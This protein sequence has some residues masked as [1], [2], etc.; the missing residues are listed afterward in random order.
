MPIICNKFLG[1]LGCSS[2]YQVTFTE[3]GLPESGLLCSL[4]IGCSVPQ[5]N[6]TLDGAAQ[7]S[8]GAAITT[9]Y[10]TQN[11]TYAYSITTPG[12]NNYTANPQS[13]SIEVHGS[14]VNVAV[15]FTKNNNT[16]NICY[17]PIN[18]TLGSEGPCIKVSV[19]QCIGTQPCPNDTAELYDALTLE[20]APAS[21]YYEV[22]DDTQLNE[23]VSDLSNYLS[24]K[25]ILTT[26]LTNTTG[27]LEVV[28]NNTP[29]SLKNALN[30][31]DLFICGSEVVL[32]GCREYKC[33]G[34][35]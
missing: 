25:G 24:Q 9:F 16:N 11:G 31:L 5:W 30:G 1:I 29:T 14:K 6:V 26:K 19:S 18:P 10:A 13:S 27:Y 32:S 34:R 8:T 28:T 7:S 21:N 12:T 20:L 22:L 23:T 35:G 3:T 17:N 33:W 15:N 2:G 4:G